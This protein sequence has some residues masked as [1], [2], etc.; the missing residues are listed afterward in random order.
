MSDLLLAPYLV[1]RTPVDLGR[2][3]LVP[4]QVLEDDPGW[5]I[6]AVRRPAERLVDAYRP[7]DG[8][9]PFGAVIFPVGESVGHPIDRTKLGDLSAALLAGTISS[10][11]RFAMAEEQQPANGGHMIATSENAVLLGH[12]LDASHTSYVLETGTWSTVMAIR[13]AP[14][15]EPLPKIP[16]PLELP[17]PMLGGQFDDETAAATLSILEGAGR[18]ARQLRRALDWYRVVFANSDSVGA[19][20]R[21]GAARSALEVLTGA[22]DQTKKVLRA[23]GRLLDD[24]DEPAARSPRVSKLYKNGPVEMSEAEWWF[25]RFSELRN[26]LVHAD[27]TPADLWEHQGHNQLRWTHDWL[28]DCLRAIVANVTG[29]GLLRLHPSD[30]VFPRIA[31]TYRKLML[32]DDE[33]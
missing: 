16:A 29:D 4:V 9:F 25:A 12:V 3:R 10:N 27:R 31:E 17:R 32:E 5:A 2:W 6:D 23:V 28:L 7:S 30:R 13:H 24:P 8:P 14:I 26:S 22:G 20:V 33:G 19:D 1:L 15:D 21:I 11:P 18:E